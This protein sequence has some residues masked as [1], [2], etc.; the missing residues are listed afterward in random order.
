MAIERAEISKLIEKDAHAQKTFYK[1]YFG[2]VMSICVRYLNKEEALEACQDVFIKIFNNI[3]KY[4]SNR[5][6]K[7]WMST[8]T[9]NEC[10]DRTRK[11]KKFVHR[12]LS[13]EETTVQNGLEHAIELKEDLDV[14][15]ILQLINSI[16]QEHKTVFL[17]YVVDGFSHQEIADK[18]TMKVSTSRWHLAQARKQ[19]QPL[20]QQHYLE[21]APKQRKYHQRQV[22]GFRPAF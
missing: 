12:F 22:V 10:I 11:H 13:I 8:I 18:L 9:I 7:K 16:K 15:Y 17:M 14:K 1:T 2:Y 3:S 5:P 6:L 19:L 20:V 4:D 21:D